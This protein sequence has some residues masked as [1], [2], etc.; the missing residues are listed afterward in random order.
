VLIAGATL[1][2]ASLSVGVLGFP[3]GVVVGAAPSP[4]SGSPTGRI[5]STGG[6]PAGRTIASIC[7]LVSLIL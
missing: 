4:T 1:G 6:T 5:T 3:E 7:A 2:A